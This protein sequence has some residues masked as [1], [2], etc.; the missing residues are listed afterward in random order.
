MRVMACLRLLW[1]GR[2]PASVWPDPARSRRGAAI[3]VMPS[4]HGTPG[5]AGSVRAGYP[6]WRAGWAKLAPLMIAVRERWRKDR[7]AGCRGRLARPS[8]GLRS[9]ISPLHTATPTMTPA[10]A[11]QCVVER[12]VS[13]GALRTAFSQAAYGGRC[14]RAP[15]S[16]GG[17]PSQ[18]AFPFLTDLGH[19]RALRFPRPAGRRLSTAK[20]RPRWWPV[21]VASPRV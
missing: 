5:R 8:S 1:Y 14:D 11:L 18:P 13:Q 12:Q 6:I 19:I 2:A 17:Q 16:T 7:D 4:G 15:M 21:E 20:L 9:G 3:V 10:A